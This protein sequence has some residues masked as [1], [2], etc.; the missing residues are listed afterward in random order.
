MSI[1]YTDCICHAHCRLT[2]NYLLISYL[3][4]LGLPVWMKVPTHLLVDQVIQS[5][6]LVAIEL[7]SSLKLYRLVFFSNC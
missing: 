3:T 2:K 4:G 7:K 6:H 5:L 1:H